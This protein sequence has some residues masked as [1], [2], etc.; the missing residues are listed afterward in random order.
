MPDVDLDDGGA[1]GEDERLRELLA[2]DRA[3]HRL[4]GL[5]AVRV[6]RAAE[7]GDVDPGEPPQ[8]PVDQAGRKGPSPG[9][10][11][12]GTATAR[13]VIAGLDGLDE[14]GD[15]L[16]RILEIAV[17]GHDDRAPRPGETGV[18]RGM[19][20]G[21]PLQAHRADTRV[22]GVDPLERRERAVGRAVVDVEDLVRA[23]ERLER[24]REALLE[25]VERRDLVVQRH[26]DRELGPP[27]R[28]LGVLGSAQRLRPRHRPRERTRAKA[29]RRPRP[30]SETEFRQVS[31]VRM[32]CRFIHKLRSR[33]PAAVRARDAQ[34]SAQADTAE[35]ADLT[36]TSV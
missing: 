32:L 36:G 21:V 13:D 34:A 19:L 31:F 7:V 26:D 16:G 25:L 24:R 18:H 9:V 2:A 23:P 10:A 3:E 28:L 22:V 12:R 17:H 8:H 35:V 1:A 33:M 20:A 5:A 29:L 27:G 6:E 30:V 14:R 11:P 4:H 15:V